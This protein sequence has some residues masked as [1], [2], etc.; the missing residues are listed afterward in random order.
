MIDP[1]AASAA[2]VALLKATNTAALREASAAARAVADTARHAGDP[3]VL[4]VRRMLA[5]AS[6]LLAEHAADTHDMDE[7]RALLDDLE[8]TA[9]ARTRLFVLPS[10]ASRG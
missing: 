4:H 7:H 8:A 9:A 10:A 1:A 2:S 3:G 6:D 5:Q